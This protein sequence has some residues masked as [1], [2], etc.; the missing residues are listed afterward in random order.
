MTMNRFLRILVVLCTVASVP[1]LAQDVVDNGHLKQTIINNAKA[2]GFTQNDLQNY[3][4]RDAYFDESANTTIAYLQQTV[5]GIDV[6]NAIATVSFRNDKLVSIESSWIPVA[7]DVVKKLATKTSVTPVAALQRAAQDLNISLPGS[8]FTA[9]RQDASIQEFEYDNMGV[10]LNNIL[11]QLMWVPEEVTGKLRLGWQVSLLSNKDNGAYLVKIDALTGQVF[12]KTNL[13][14]KDTWGVSNAK[15]FHTM[16][17]YEVNPADALPANAHADFNASPDGA[18]L[19]DTAKFNVIPYPNESPNQA[20]PTLVTNPWSINGLA[21]AYTDRWNTDNVKDYDSLKGNNVQAYEDINHDNKAGYSP[22]SST[23]VPKVTFNFFPDYTVNP[24]SDIFTE[25]F[26]ITNLFYM[27]NM[28]HDM[29]Y[30]Y[31]F[32]EAAGNLQTYNFGRGGKQADLLLAEAFDGSDT[33][34]ANMAPAVDGQKCR[35]QMF[36]WYGSPLKVLQFNAPSPSD[37]LGVMLAAESNL[38]TN[39]KLSQTGTIT[40]NVVFYNDQS[41]STHKGCVAASNASALAGKIAYI[42]RGGCTF[43]VKLKNAQNAGARAVIVGDSLTVGSRLVIMSGTDNTI[44]VPGVF[45][46]Y[47]D[48]QKLKADLSNT[49]N[50]VNASEKF[51]PYI[52][53]DLDN[54]VISHEYGHAISNR[55]TG[56]PSTVSCLNNGEQPGEGWSDYFALMMTTNWA[57]AKLSDSSK[58]RPIGN[59]VVGYPADSP[60]IRYYPYCKNLSTDPWTLDL[61][62]SDTSVHE[63]TTADPGSIYPN[64]E[65]WCSVLW[66]MTWDLCKAKGINTNLFKYVS[67][68]GNSIAMKLV[69]QGMK[70]QKCSP[71]LLDARNAILKADT[72]LFAKAYSPLIWKA[73]ARRGLGYSATQGLNTKIKDGTAAYDLPPGVTFAPET[74]TTVAENAVAKPVVTVSPNPATSNVNVYMKGN[75]K[76][77]TVRLMNN[78]GATLGTYSLNGESLNINVSGYAAGIYNILIT[79][80]DT[81][82]KYRLVIQ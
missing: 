74:G 42:D 35:T 16:Y 22:K 7:A 52:D 75:T 21:N 66:D 24:T 73:F 5:K 31:A 29:S 55:F 43:V 67:T 63:Y 10:A 27:E 14:A 11:V 57:T 76:A 20:N 15:N 18:L 3:R 1:A 17:A 68:K 79:G 78:A 71:G 56:G 80:D 25:S 53:G 39:N 62:K 70:L 44:T 32:N 36:Q 41:A 77:L 65:L 26:G 40:Q 46:R 34:N 54:G 33:A 82:V 30:N 12:N 64:G 9:L 6:Y 38:S 47:A 8:F 59:Y 37:I 60:G 13:T 81:D 51:A 61:I 2:L 4:I 72:T 45:V 50:T 19:V 49:S 28:M 58:P 23:A 48:A 69:M